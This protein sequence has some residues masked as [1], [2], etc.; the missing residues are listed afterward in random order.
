M[1][2]VHLIVLGQS[3]ELFEAAGYD[4]RRWKIVKTRGRRRPLRYD[5]GGKLG[6]FIASASDIDDLVPI[7]TAYQIES[8]KMHERLRR[9]AGSADALLDITRDSVA[10]SS[11]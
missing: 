8:N 5:G 2:D 3:H 6:V 7:L 11:A 10:L 4:V 1:L 9:A